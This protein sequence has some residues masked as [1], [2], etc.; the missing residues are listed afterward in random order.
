MNWYETYL[1]MKAGTALDEAH[2]R[3]LNAVLEQYPFFA[4]GRMMM[5]KVATKLNDPRA[6]QLRFLGALYAPSR[7]HYAFFLEERMRPRV[8][9]PPRVSTTGRETQTPPARTE[10]KEEP[11]SSG[12]EPGPAAMP[13]SEA[14]SPPLQGWIAARQVLYGGMGRRLRAQLAAYLVENVPRAPSLLTESAEPPSAQAEGQSAPPSSGQ[15]LSSSE[16]SAP[17]PMDAPALATPVPATPQPT[18]EAPPTVEEQHTEPLPSTAP[19]SA[20]T[21]PGSTQEEVAPPVQHL[22]EESSS[23]S[24]P[25]LPVFTEF[26]HHVTFSPIGIAT[27]LQLELPSALGKRH[28]A[29]PDSLSGEV[30]PPPSPPVA[31]ESAVPTSVSSEPSGDVSPLTEASAPIATSSGTDDLREQFHRAYIPLEL[32]EAPIRSFFSQEPEAAPEAMQPTPSPSLPENPAE[33]REQFHR[34]YVPLEDVDREIHL[35]GNMEAPS[36]AGTLPPS[37]FVSDSPIRSFIPLQIDVGASIHL[38]IPEPGESPAP[39]EASGEAATTGEPLEAVQAEPTI[40]RG[41]H[42]FLEEIQKELPLTEAPAS[43]VTK[44]LEDL[45]REFIRRLLAQRPAHSPPA[46]VSE[47]ENVI[48]L[49]LRKIEAFHPQSTPTV[50]REVPDLTIPG[51][52]APAAT[53]KVYTETMARLYWSQGDAVRAI[54]VYEGLI[55]KHPENAE[56]Y[57]QQIERIRSGDMP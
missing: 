44:E 39:I 23:R 28:D 18:E 14:F 46:N 20:Y 49:L 52:E 10:K 32:P 11:T 27:V 38:P 6:Q 56:Y 42:S 55:Q 7:Q 48:D 33:L 3:E 19:S 45:R 47:G 41:W 9:P 43:P 34:E 31:A 15:V 40:I 8:S 53:P 17:A 16:I 37:W 24:T 30:P 13:Y 4:L 57:R 36:P 35:T 26:R 54:Q 51:W 5:A 2:L 1:H 22:V 29:P 50:E 25:S 12:D 21:S